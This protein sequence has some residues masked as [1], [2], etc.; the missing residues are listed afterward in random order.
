M[1]R[2]FFNV[3]DSCAAIDEEGTVLPSLAAAREEALFAASTVLRDSG[4]ELWTGCPWRMEVTDHAGSS[5][6]TLHFSFEP[7]SLASAT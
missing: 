4:E 7:T 5:L 3:H 1:P 6:F 2:Y